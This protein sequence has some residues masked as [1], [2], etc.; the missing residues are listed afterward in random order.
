VAATDPRE[1]GEFWAIDRDLESL[2]EFIT[3]FLS[4]HHR[5]TSPLFIAGESYGGFRVARMTRKLQENHGVGLCGALLISPAIEYD[6]QFGTDY[7]LTHWIEVFPSLAAAAHFHGRARNLQPDAT[8]DSVRA[9]AEEFACTQLARLLIRGDLL[10]EQ[11][12]KDILWRA[13]DFVG[14]PFDLLDR[15]GG[16][17]SAKTFCRQ[18]L[19]DERRL[20]GR[21][22]ASVTTVDP[23]PDRNDYEGPDPTVLSIKRLFTGA[24][25][26][27]L[28][29][30]LGV[31]TDLD[32]RLFSWEVNW[33]WRDDSKGH[34]F[35][36]PLGAM[37][38]LRFGMSLNE[39]MRIFVV[40]GHFDLVTPYHSSRRLVELMKL[41]AA[42]RRNLIVRSFDGG[43]MFY[44]WE[45]SR[46]AFRNE[47]ERFYTTATQSG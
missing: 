40:H 16:R 41:T 8:G 14:L 13:S 19:R 28:R 42:H 7:S 37:D 3:R 34:V 29:F 43:H 47:A 10:S 38:E 46:K 39:H 25:N 32:Y 18:L 21:L 35:R 12:R 4:K 44:L 22:D 9:L 36:R 15:A 31:H 30:N 5:W 1:N 26:H 45:E 23:F 17:I 33:A 27:H 24:V 20:C 2:G 11:E 6:S